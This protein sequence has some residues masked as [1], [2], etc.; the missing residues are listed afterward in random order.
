MKVNVVKIIAALAIFSSGLWMAGLGLAIKDQFFYEASSPVKKISLEN[1]A[2]EKEDGFHIV[3]L[4]DSLTRG[5][6][7]ESGKGYV[8]YVADELQTKTKQTIR[9]KNLAIKGQRS[10]GLVSQL[11]QIEVQRQIKQADI[12]LMTIGG[13]DLFQSGEALSNFSLE[14]MNQAKA[15]YLRN[16]H[17]IFKTIRHLNPDAVVFYISLYNPFNDLTDAKTTSAVVREWNFQSA[18]AAANYPNIIA[19]PTF[20]LFE[21]NVNDY[22]YSDKFHPNKE[23]YKL[24][25]ERVAS[26]ITFTEGDEKND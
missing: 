10:A 14:R 1:V 20:D 5:T 15:D 16:L 24:I 19:V 7:D 17:T 8:G 21:L 9:V 4:G 25:G 26:L 12:I 18:E 6:G 2:E 3:A 11:Q 22:L 23:G 13:N